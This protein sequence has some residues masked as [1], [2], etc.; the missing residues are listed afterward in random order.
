MTTS[1][2]LKDLR[3]HGVAVEANGGYLDLD[4][5]PAHLLTTS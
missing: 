5:P 3:S 4:P 2:L 1:E